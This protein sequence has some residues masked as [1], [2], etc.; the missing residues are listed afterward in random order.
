[1]VVQQPI[2]EKT[3]E[4][5]AVRLEWRQIGTGVAEALRDHSRAVGLGK[6][7][8]ACRNV[9]SAQREQYLLAGFVEILHCVSW[10]SP[11][12]PY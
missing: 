1:M 12:D 2:M 5:V 11:P 10:F 3:F 7:A 9:I 8:T 6:I 4:Y